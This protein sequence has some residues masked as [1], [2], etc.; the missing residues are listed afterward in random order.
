MILCCRSLSNYYSNRISLAIVN[1]A[2]IFMESAL[3]FVICV[4]VEVMMARVINFSLKFHV[5]VFIA[6]TQRNL[7]R[8]A[9]N[10]FYLIES[11]HQRAFI[12]QGAHFILIFSLNFITSPN[13]QSNYAI[14]WAELMSTSLNFEPKCTDLAQ[15]YCPFMSNF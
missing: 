3:F 1:V 5:T 12:F 6:I 10:H 13:L 14:C 2:K 4:L 7:N 8:Q 15:E 11:H 9:R